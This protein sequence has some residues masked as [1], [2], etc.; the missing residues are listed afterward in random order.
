MEKFLPS[1]VNSNSNRW[2]KNN[3]I[4]FKKLNLTCFVSAFV[5]LCGFV[6]TAY[7]QTSRTFNSSG[8]FTVPDG[9]TQVTV[10]LW[11]GGG[12][13]GYNSTTGRPASGGGGGAYTKKN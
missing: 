13:G 6:P 10:E 12:G 7:S 11:G 3:I 5:L 8:T 9:V 4:S 1:V 2:K